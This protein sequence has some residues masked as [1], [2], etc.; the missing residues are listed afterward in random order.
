MFRKAWVNKPRDS[1]S[2]PYPLLNRFSSESK[3]PETKPSGL[4]LVS[5]PRGFRDCHSSME[6][7]QEM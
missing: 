6:K 4:T 7:D 1:D 5:P 2:V 3:A